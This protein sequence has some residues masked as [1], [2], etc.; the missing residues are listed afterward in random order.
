MTNS[1][2]N[3]RS[4]EASSLSK[5][6]HIMEVFTIESPELGLGEISQKAGL[7]KS[8]VHRLL[9]T[10]C[11]QEWVFQNEETGKYTVGMRVFQI[12]AIAVEIRG[13]GHVLPKHLAHLSEQTGETTHVSIV[14]DGE[15]VYV[16]KYE[17][18]HTIRMVSKVGSKAPLHCTAM[19]KIHLAFMPNQEAVR[20]IEEKGL[21]RYTPV[22]IVSKEQLLAQL[23]VIRKDGYAIHDGEYEEGV[24]CVSAPIYNYT[25][26]AIA[27]MSVSG[28]SYRMRLKGLESF[29]KPVIQ[30]AHDI[31]MDLGY[32][33]NF[34]E[35]SHQ[36]S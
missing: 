8:T 29:I 19:G 1:V 27:A 11:S 14:D 5:A 31:S 15:L 33:G 16:S 30:T 12:G 34:S 26:K 21:K 9:K 2:E 18:P 36:V 32:L 28:P 4:N 17:G 3:D 23:E 24:C 13:L 20:I 25:G 22:T 6:L 10:L 7:N 35:K